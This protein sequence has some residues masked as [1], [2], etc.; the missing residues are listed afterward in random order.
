MSYSPIAQLRSVLRV[1]RPPTLTVGRRCWY[2]RLLCRSLAAHGCAHPDWTDPA[3]AVPEVYTQE[4]ADA[5]VTFQQKH[6]L[7]VDGIVGPETWA[8]LT[9]PPLNGDSP[10]PQQPGQLALAWIRREALRGAR[11]IGGNNRG[12][13]VQKYTRS[14][15]HPDG[16]QG[17]PWCV[18]SASWCRRGAHESLGHKDPLTERASTSELVIE[19]HEAG[20]LC[21]A[22]ERAILIGRQRPQ[23]RLLVPARKP[24]PGSYF[25]VLGGSTGAKHTGLLERFEGNRALVWE[26][27]VRPRKWIPFQRDAVR[28]GSYRLNQ[29]VFAGGV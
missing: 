18:Y 2:V 4:L 23:R 11:E 5:V 28:P 29:V 17:Q 15:R 16:I 1:K 6:G 27:N 20:L 3:V 24:I 14:A 8:W 21:A 7:N 12:P 22:S 9:L 25:C 13:F 26:G 19:A 10:R